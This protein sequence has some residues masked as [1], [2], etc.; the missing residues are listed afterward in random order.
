MRTHSWP[1]EHRRSGLCRTALLPSPCLRGRAVPAPTEAQSPLTPPVHGEPKARLVEARALA[2]IGRPVYDWR[3][4]RVIACDVPAGSLLAGFGGPDDYRDCF[5]REVAGAVSLA[6]FIERFYCSAAFRPERIVLGL[7]G[8]GASN[9][10]ARAL[11]RGETDRIAVWEV[12]ER[13]SATSGPQGRSRSRRRRRPQ[14]TC[15]PARS[16]ATEGRVSEE[17]PR[18]RMAPPASEA[19]Q[20]DEILLLSKS[21]GT[22]SWLAVEPLDDGRTKLLFGS[23]VGNLGQSGWR[24]MGMP[25]QFYSWV[26]LGAA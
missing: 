7:I 14:A 1:R 5:C 22:A 25:H 12:I 13:R 15:K 24:F 3:M 11:A 23:W 26:L 17:S 6:A 2:A 19:Q 10:D 20:T 8:R 16:D 4:A 18:G 9:A 21:T